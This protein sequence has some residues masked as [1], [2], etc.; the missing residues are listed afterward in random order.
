MEAQIYNN[1]AE[2]VGTV[3]LDE[4]FFG[5]SWNADLVHQ[6]I[7]SLQANRRLKVAFVKGRGDVRGGGKKPWRQKGTGRA[8]HG[9]I[10]SPIWIG[11]GVT[12]GPTAERDYHQ[13]IN[14]KAKTRALFVILSKKLKD[15]EMLLLDKLFS[16][17]VP[18]TKLA[19]GVIDKLATI[20]GFEK[21]SYRS[22]RRLLL[23]TPSK[24]AVAVKSFA[25]LQSAK[26]MEARDLNPLDLATYK[27]TIIISPK[28]SLATL[29]R[30][31]DF[32]AGVKKTSVKPKNKPE[33]AKVGR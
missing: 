7:R 4:R 6:V 23:V 13:K 2:A 9:S 17:S 29:S 3:K 1:K 21:I 20:T 25:N 11:G 10:R 8:R 5:L 33:L 14:Q 19:Q 24:D 26:V 31:G 32:L 18:K 12:H 28:E 16:V 22:G 27:Y 30:R 15:G